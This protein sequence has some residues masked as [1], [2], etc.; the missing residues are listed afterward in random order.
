M[1]ILYI[2]LW[3][4]VDL[5]SISGAFSDPVSNVFLNLLEII[6]PTRGHTTTFK[7]IDYMPIFCAG[8]WVLV[9]VHLKKSCHQKN[10]CAEVI[11]NPNGHFWKMHEENEAFLFNSIP[12]TL[13]KEFYAVSPPHPRQLINY[14]HPTPQPALHHHMQMHSCWISNCA[15][16]LPVVISSYFFLFEKK[17]KFMFNPLWLYLNGE[18]I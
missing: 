9:C 13:F 6:F 18:V 1:H 3:T 7:K 16:I 5:C 17:K 12:P 14:P 2:N 8:P 15:V 11:F 4:F 10:F